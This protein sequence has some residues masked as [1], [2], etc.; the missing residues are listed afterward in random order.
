MF[1]H[2]CHT[3]HGS[4]HGRAEIRRV[5]DA[6][7]QPGVDEILQTRFYLASMVPYVEYAITHHSQNR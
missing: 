6:D 7:D 5:Y 2:R 4:R 3:K 1:G